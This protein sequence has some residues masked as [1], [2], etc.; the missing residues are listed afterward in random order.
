MKRMELMEKYAY[1]LGLPNTWKFVDVWGLEDDLL[2]FIPKPVKAVIL[3][4]PITS[5]VRKVLL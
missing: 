3:L 1:S 5:A 4:F 2:S